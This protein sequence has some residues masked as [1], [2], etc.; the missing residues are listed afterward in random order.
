M[1]ATDIARSVALHKT[2]FGIGYTTVGSLGIPFLV[3]RSVQETCREYWNVNPP[4][5][6][7][8][9]AALVVMWAC[10]WLYY[11]TIWKHEVA[12]SVR[13]NPGFQEMRDQEKGSEQ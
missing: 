8:I 4:L 10:G 2:M 12:F 1:T 3:A 11:W 13:N 6:I 9:P 5:S 7:L